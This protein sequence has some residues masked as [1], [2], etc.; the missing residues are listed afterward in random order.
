MAG[1]QF[2][3]YIYDILIFSKVI[4][5]KI[6]LKAKILKRAKTNFT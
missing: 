5:N 2:I 3:V 6:D 1:T 4:K